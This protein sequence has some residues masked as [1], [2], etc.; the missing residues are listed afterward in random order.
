M[1]ETEIIRTGAW[2]LRVLAVPYVLCSQMNILI[3]FFK[4]AGDVNVAFWASL[5]QVFI[6]LA[7][8]FGLSPIPSIGINAVWFSMP[9]TWLLV[10]AFCALYYKS[11][12]WE[13]YLRRMMGE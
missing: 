3:S 11:H 7:V 4:G 13:R 2:G 1:D 12:R 10:G 8:S 5:S 6:R 9:L